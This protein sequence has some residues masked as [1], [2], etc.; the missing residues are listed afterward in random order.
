MKFKGSGPLTVFCRMKGPSGR[1]REVQAIIEPSF[2]YCLVLKNDAM[3]LGYPSVTFRPEDWMDTNPAEV[4]NLISIKGVEVGTKIKLKEVSVGSLK[5]RDVEAV[6]TKS[7]FPLT[8]PVGMFLGRSFL[9]HFRL[10]VDPKAGAFSLE[11]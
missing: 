9:R 6:V 8:I 11:E 3:Q 4:T 10:K 7:E 2:E 5:A 1:V